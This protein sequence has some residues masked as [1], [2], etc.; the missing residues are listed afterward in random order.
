[1]NDAP[2]FITREQIEQQQAERLPS[3]ARQAQ[4]HLSAE[5]MLKE[6]FL[7]DAIEL[8]SADV[9]ES[10]RSFEELSDQER[11]DIFRRNYEHVVDRMGRYYRLYEDRN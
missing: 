3:V 10:G 6:V 5:R 1:M 11:A 9:L 7:Q 4:V 8:S 2:G